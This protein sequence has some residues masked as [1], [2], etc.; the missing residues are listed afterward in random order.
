M[1]ARRRLA[2][3]TKAGGK[4]YKSPEAS[5]TFKDYEID[6]I[7]RALGKHR[8]TLSKSDDR[9]MPERDMAHSLYMVFGLERRIM[10]TYTGKEV[11][12][13]QIGQQVKKY[14]D[15]RTEREVT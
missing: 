2:F 13:D 7:M 11:D 6:V 14:A 9:E 5:F 15:I 1:A 12:Y 8:I 3:D 10:P 4:K